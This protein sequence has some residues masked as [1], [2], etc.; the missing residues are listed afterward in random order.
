M[1]RRINRLFALLLLSAPLASACGDDDAA[2]E[3]SAAE[4]SDGVDNDGDGRTDCDDLACAVHAFCASAEDAG[5]RD[6]GSLDAGLSEDAAAPVDGGEDAAVDAATEMDAGTDSGRDGGT[7]A[8]S[9]AGSDA[10]TDAGTPDAGADAGAPDAGTDAGT[11]DAGADAGAPDAG[12]LCGDFASPCTPSRGCT[13]SA[14]CQRP[15]PFE[16]GGVDDAIRDLPPGT[17]TMG[18]FFPGGY[19]TPDDFSGDTLNVCDPDDPA[20]PTCGPCGACIDLGQDSMCARTCAPNVT[21]NSDCRD[22]GYTCDLS[23]EVCFP[24]CNGDWECRIS[25]E[26]TN[27]IPGIQTPDDCERAPADCGGSTSGF[28][29]LV[30]DTSS[31]AVCN[32]DTWR[33]EFPG[34]STAEG[35][36]PCTRSDEE[37]EANGR[38]LSEDEFGWPSGYCTKFRCDLPGNEC[39]GG[40]VCETRRV[41][42]PL[43]LAGCTVATGA[44]ADPSSWLSNTG[45]CR[46]GYACVWNGRDPA[47][48]ANNGHCLPGEFNAVTTE[49][50]G[51][52]CDE[53]ADCWSPFGQAFCFVDDGPDSGFPGGYCSL[54]DCGVPGMPA[55][56]CGAG[57]VC[58]DLDGAD[59]DITGCL[60]G[61]TR[62]DECRAGYACSDL[63]GMPG[64]QGA[65]LESCSDDG[66][67]RS[68]EVCS[69]PA[70][71]S[72]GTCV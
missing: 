36:D 29:A 35:G 40:A 56:V 58:I 30:Y 18:V 60:A 20:D 22:D 5:R 66:E 46:T 42:T 28:D 17:D 68:G 41:G 61:C 13:S 31:L 21:D 65:C 4:C 69:I 71:E 34:S 37:C 54:L 24:G 55:E 44:T 10:G 19:C 3:L 11:P 38:C 15:L 53:D 59:G 25:R 9:A 23:R 57:N 47:G 32:P 7:D 67:C 64:G 43:C 16:L 52:P 33:C 6:A 26:D 49:N 2:T 63:D 1:P 50:I 39:A 72:F 48:A 8:G 62:A 12:D 27:G 45:G 51:E 14:F 70:G